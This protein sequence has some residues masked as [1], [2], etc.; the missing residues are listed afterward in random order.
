[1]CSVI[2]A[3]SSRGEQWRLLGV[4][5]FQGFV[6]SLALLVFAPVWD[7][8]EV[9][10]G[11]YVILQLIVLS[12]WTMWWVLWRWSPAYR[13]VYAIESAELLVKTGDRVRRRYDLREA[14]QVSAYGETDWLHGWYFLG[15]GWT[16]FPRVYLH[17][18]HKIL[19][20]GT[21][22]IFLWGRNA[23]A[24]L[25]TRVKS[26]HAQLKAGEETI[27]LEPWIYRE[28]PSRIDRILRFGWWMFWFQWAIMLLI[29]VWI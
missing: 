22:P 14:D 16:M 20:K 15:A 4:M 29:F 6:L 1:M 18:D 9:F 7:D 24:D 12:A 8:L 5:G 13:S 23:I 10:I 21:K 2:L 27:D 11:F 19:N 17:F 26:V 3:E 25:D 28:T